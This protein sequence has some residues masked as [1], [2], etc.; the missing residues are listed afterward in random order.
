[1]KCP[2]HRVLL[3][4]QRR[5]EETLS[6]PR[7]IWNYLLQ[8]RRFVEL[9]WWLEKRFK[10][11]LVINISNEI[12]LF[13][14]PVRRRCRVASLSISKTINRFCSIVVFHLPNHPSLPRRR[15]ISSI[16]LFSM[17]FKRLRIR[18]RPRRRME[19][20]KMNFTWKF[21]SLLWP[22]PIKRINLIPT[23]L[24]AMNFEVTFG[25]VIEVH[26]P[27]I[28]IQIQRSNPSSNARHPETMSQEK[29]SA[30]WIL[31]HR[32]VLSSHML[33][34]RFSM[35]FSF[36]RDKCCA[37]D[38]RNKQLEDKIARLICNRDTERTDLLSH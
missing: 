28:A 12:K 26:R 7:P 31:N 9:K 23:N 37:F 32:F 22:R 11:S 4:I 20:S 27:A 1:M 13:H 21:P 10:V 25:V 38:E 33:F 36:I 29:M 30:L 35:L 14:R 19:V 34:I 17:K 3:A 18:N 2:R 8:R 16:F 5:T 24:Y 15:A 6:L